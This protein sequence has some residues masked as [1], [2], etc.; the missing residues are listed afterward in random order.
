MPSNINVI[1]A[2]LKSTFSGLKFCR[3]QY[4]SI[5]IRVAVV[6]SQICEITRNSEKI[7]TYSSSG[8]S[9]VIALGANRKRVC[10]F[11]LVINSNFGL[12]RTVFEILTH[13]A[14]VENSSFCA[15]HPCLTPPLTG[16]P[17]EFLD[18]TNLSRKNQGDGANPTR[19]R[20]TTLTC[21]TPT[22]PARSALLR[23]TRKASCRWQTRATLAKRLHGL[24]KSSG[25]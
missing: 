11:L 21:E 22:M 23:V 6:A 16:N 9:K 15:P 12:S 17:S 10:N 1:Y 7:R 19:R 4:R 3:W 5:F 25:L 2:S 18:E 13:K 8:S 14:R 24:C 20:A